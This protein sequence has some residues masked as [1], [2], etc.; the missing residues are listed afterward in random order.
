M[1]KLTIAARNSVKTFIE[2]LRLFRCLE[3]I[4]TAARFAHTITIQNILRVMRS[5]AQITVG[6]FAHVL[7]IDTVHRTAEK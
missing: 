1:K 4:N 6:A 3:T 7:I 5:R 2:S